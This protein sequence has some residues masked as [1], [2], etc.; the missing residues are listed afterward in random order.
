MPEAAA[1]MP[2]T[3][4]PAPITSATS[5]PRRC[6]AA[7]SLAIDSTWAPSTPY[8]RSPIR[9]SPE[10]FRRTRDV[11]KAAF[12]TSRAVV[13]TRLACQRDALEFHHLGARVGEGLADRL[14]RVVDPLLVV[15]HLRRVEALVQHPLDDLVLRLLGLALQLVRVAVDVEL[16]GDD[17][18]RDVVAA[19]P[20]RRRGGDVH[21]HLPTEVVVAAPQLDEHPELVRRGMGV[22]LDDAALDLLE[23]CR[24]HDHDVLAEPGRELLSLLLEALLG[25]DAALPDGVEHLLRERE[26]LVVVGDRLGLA[27]DPDDDAGSALDPVGD[28]A[29]AGLPAG[30]LRDLGEPALAE[31]LLGRLDVSARFLEGALAVHHPRTGLVA[32]LLDERCGDLGHAPSSWLAVAASSCVAGSTASCSAGAASGSASAA[33]AGS[34]LVV[35]AAGGSGPS[36]SAG[37]RAGAI[38]AGRTFCLPCSIASAITRVTRLH[39]RIASSL[40]GIT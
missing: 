1:S 13:A 25:P 31:D 2:R 16:G 24:R 11:P 19:D 22:A 38:S 5:R 23:P 32:E 18:L 27:A 26:E 8:A 14:R 17:L 10:S 15:Q 40:P 29:L 4:F 21:R 37:G 20:L 39:E 35:G 36:A 28:L 30:A 6:T 7:I 3:M 12:G 34:P 33:G 9:A